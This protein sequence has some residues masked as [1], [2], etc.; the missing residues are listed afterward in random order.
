MAITAFSI[1]NSP[2]WGLK[3]PGEAFPGELRPSGSQIHRAK[4]FFGLQYH[5][6]TVLGLEVAGGNLL[7]K[8]SLSGLQNLGFGGAWGLKI[9]PGF[10]SIF[11]LQTLSF[12]ALGV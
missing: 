7:R 8:I 1:T 2:F 5:K 3:G 10:L 9:F 11:G 4:G 12:G 6:F